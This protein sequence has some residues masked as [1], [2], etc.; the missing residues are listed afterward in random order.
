MSE[1]DLKEWRKAI[2]RGRKI[3]ELQRD[4][5][6]IQR[7]IDALLRRAEQRGIVVRNVLGDP[8][9]SPEHYTPLPYIELVRQVLGEIDL[10]PASNALAQ[11]W[12]RARTFYT[13]ADDGLI[14]P[15]GGAVYLNPPYESSEVRLLGRKFLEKAIAEYQV[16]TITAAVILLNRTGAQW[17]KQ[18]QEQVTAVC[19]VYKRI[20]FI[21]ENGAVQQ[22]PRYYNDFLYLGTEPE[23][24]RDVFGKIGKVQV[25]RKI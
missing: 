15:W 16:G 25:L 9:A 18:L 10:D 5:R 24:F 20:A 13:K 1:A 11:T 23:R 22:S 2:A 6:D 21:S 3:V 12:I 17:Y 7:R 14:Q 4:I 19:E 8:D